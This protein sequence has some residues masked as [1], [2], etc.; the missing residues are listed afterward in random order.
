MFSDN[1]SKASEFF[2]S[3]TKY[4]E[5]IPPSVLD[6]SIDTW[7]NVPYYGKIDI[8]GTPV[9]PKE[10]LLINLDI[11]G[12]F[13]AINFVADAFKDLQNSINLAKSKKGYKPSFLGE[14][15]PKKAWQS[16]AELFDTYF[17]NNIYNVFLNNFLLGKTI[18]SFNCFVKQYVNFCKSV[19]E[20]TSLTLSSFILSNNCSNK[21]SGLI[22]DISDDDHDDAETKIKNYFDDYQYIS[23]LTSCQSHG[24]KINKN[25]PW[26]LIA[27]LSNTQMKK[28]AFVRGIDTSDNG[29]FNKL[30]YRSSTIGYDSFKTYLWQMYSDWFKVNTTYSRIQVESKFNSSSPMYSHFETKKI[31]E[32][33]V[34]LSTSKSE[35]FDTYGELNFLK[36]YFKIRLIEVNM[37]DKYD[38]LIHHVEQ[39]YN[40]GLTRASLAYID[41]KLTKTNIYT[42]NELNP[43]FFN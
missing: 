11:D 7:Y 42:S 8:Y 26:Q 32:L 27:D 17:E 34:E 19:A 14:F 4:D 38:D 36:L 21:I 20:D 6:K 23:F 28:Y 16:A 35:L 5:S 18:S 29:L 3:K 2:S 33:P 25:A 39:Y 13:Q 12:D 9:Y 30:Y 43:Y 22:I 31:N 37:E 41:K 40:L 15:E 1:S 24:F 10:L